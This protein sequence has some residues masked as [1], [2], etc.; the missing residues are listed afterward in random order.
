[1]QPDTWVSYRLTI[2]RGAEAGARGLG[3]YKLA[4]LSVWSGSQKNPGEAESGCSLQPLHVP[5]VSP[6]CRNSV[7]HRKLWIQKH[8]HLQSGSPAQTGVSYAPFGPE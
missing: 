8:V 1:M 2:R 4:P 7:A 3:V 6:S 5:K